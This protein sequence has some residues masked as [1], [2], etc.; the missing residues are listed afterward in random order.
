MNAHSPIPVND[1]FTALWAKGYRDILPIIPIDAVL[2]PSSTITPDRLGKIPGKLTP[3]GWVGFGQWSEYRTA[4]QDVE[5][6]SRWGCGAGLQCRDGLL[7]IDADTLRADLASVIRVEVDRALGVLPT[8]IGNAPKALFLCRA[9]PGYSHP[10]VIFDGGVLE[11]RTSLQFVVDGVHPATRKPYRWTQKLVDYDKLPVFSADV[12]DALWDRLRAKLPNGRFASSKTPSAAP[13]QESLKAPSVDFVRRAVRSIPNDYA[14]R[15]FYRNMAYATKAA[16]PDQP[17]EAVE[18]FVGWC[19]GWDH[20]EGNDPD[21]VEKEWR[22]LSPPF[23]IGWSWLRDAANARTPGTVDFAEEWHETV[24]EP[25]PVIEDTYESIFAGEEKYEA[26]PPLTGTVYSAPAE[27]IPPRQFLYGHHYLRQY[28]S[29]TIAPTKVGKTSLGVVEALAMCSGKPLLGVKPTGLW[30]VRLWNGEDPAEE[31]DRR[32]AAAMQEY[33]LTME[34]IGDRLLRDSGRDMPICV[35]VQG[36]D[37][38][39]I[40]R[41]VVAALEAA[42]EAQRLD[43]LGVDP[44]VKSHGVSENDNMAVDLVVREWNGVAGRTRIAIDL[45]HHSRK[46]NGGEVSIDDARGASALVSAARSA[47]VLARMTKTEGQRLGKPKDFRRYFRFADA[48]SNMAAPASEE[49]AWMELKSVDLRNGVFDANGAILWP[50]DQVGVVKLSGLKGA[51]VAAT[52]EDEKAER[53]ALRDLAGGE[54]RDDIRSRGD[55]AGVVVARAYGLDLDDL[56]E[57]ERVKALLKG[58]I[59]SGKL[60]TEIRKDATSRK[61]KVFVRTALQSVMEDS[62]DLFG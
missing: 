4:Q 54:W 28:V 37:G 56:D 40:W 32:I 62:S 45:V 38:A 9:P 1:V 35:A 3:N 55:W 20:P 57:R 24:P 2:S 46:L 17:E 16:L 21:F 47:R 52:E 22:G 42:I 34:D 43:V 15:D 7:A 59:R 18:I 14:D 48:V 61:Q 60:T 13:P 25:P 5:T 33:G 26:A 27:P 23:K 41:P 10:N 39:K 53:Q 50:S 58:L 36:K 11:V 31:L 49:D 8:R 19:E 29:A 30:R 6:W 44:F 12:L 51:D